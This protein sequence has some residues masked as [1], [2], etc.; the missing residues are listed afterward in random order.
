MNAISIIIGLAG[1]AIGLIIGYK[2][3]KGK[4]DKRINELQ[5]QFE[6]ERQIL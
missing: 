1:L 2:I 5:T 6:K 3:Y 4:A